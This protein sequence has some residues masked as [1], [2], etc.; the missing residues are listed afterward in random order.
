MSGMDTEPSVADLFRRNHAAEKEF[1]KTWRCEYC[2]EL[3]EKQVGDCMFTGTIHLNQ[4]FCLFP[5]DRH[6]L[7]S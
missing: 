2:L 3:Y 7:T 1:K 6:R 5:E 4:S